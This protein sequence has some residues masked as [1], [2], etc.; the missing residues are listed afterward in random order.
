M[1]LFLFDFGLISERFGG[2]IVG[3]NVFFEFWEG[4]DHLG[5]VRAAKA[6]CKAKLSVTYPPKRANARLGP[7]LTKSHLCLHA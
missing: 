1:N 7:H 6:K 3:S 5:V 4:W 2:Y